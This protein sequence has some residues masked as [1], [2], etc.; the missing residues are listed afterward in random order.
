MEQNH[1]GHLGFPL[2]TILACFDPGHPAATEQVLAQS[3]KRFG[4]S[5][6][7]LIFKMAGVATILDFRSAQV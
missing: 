6:R 2:I 5:C 7:K 1:F 4:K 3:N